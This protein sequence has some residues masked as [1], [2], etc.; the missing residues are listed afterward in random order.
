MPGLVRLQQLSNVGYQRVVRIRVSEEG[1]DTQQNFANGERWAPLIFE[2]IKTDSSVGIDV[3]VVNAC[4]KVNFGRL[5]SASGMR[6]FATGI[7]ATDAIV[8]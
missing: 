1:A 6:H 7:C 2:N 5:W 8:P 4:G 3:A